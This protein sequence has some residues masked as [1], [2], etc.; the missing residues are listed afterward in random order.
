[1]GGAGATARAPR[2]AGAAPDGEP[3]GRGQRAALY[4]ASG[5]SVAAVAAGVPALDGRALLLRQVD[6]GRHLGRGESAPGGA[7]AGAAGARGPAHG[8]DYRQPE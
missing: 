3:A 4:D 8:S 1:M 7:G 2:G 6:R 5:V